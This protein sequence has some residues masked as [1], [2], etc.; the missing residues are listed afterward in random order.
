[1][2]ESLVQYVISHKEFSDSRFDGRTILF[3]NKNIA[4]PIINGTLATWTGDNIDDK[5]PFYCELTALYWIYKNITDTNCVSFEHYRRVFLSP[6]SNWFTYRFLQKDEILKILR[7]KQIILPLQHHFKST[8][9]EQYKENHIIE[10]LEIMK[11]VLLEQHPDYRETFDKTMNGHDAVLFNMFIMEKTM[12]DSYC[13]FAFSI[14]DQVYSIQKESIAQHDSYQKRAIGF[15]SE[16]LFNIWLNKN[17]DESSRFHCPVAHLDQKPFIHYA[18]N[19]F[20]KA[21]KK[22]YDGPWSKIKQ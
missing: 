7:T 21:I 17:V 2:N 9:M 4:K 5:N 1:M 6:H 16:R 20:F 22:D 15:L 19:S 3:V 11:Q 8:L 18:K 14:L 12:L 10:D 13:K